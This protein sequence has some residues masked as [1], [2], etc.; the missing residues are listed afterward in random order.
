L[1]ERAL[2]ILAIPIEDS[3]PLMFHL[4]VV[5]GRDEFVDFFIMTFEVRDN[6]IAYFLELTNRWEVFIC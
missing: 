1:S 6:L 4:R 3:S 2:I 5:L